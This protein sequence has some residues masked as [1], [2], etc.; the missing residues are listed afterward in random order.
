M[1]AIIGGATFC[2]VNYSPDHHRRHHKSV[3]GTIAVSAAKE[4]KETTRRST[5][6]AL[7]NTVIQRLS[8]KDYLER[9]KELI[10][11]DGG[12]PRWFSPLES[13]EQWSNS[14][15]LL[16]LPGMDGVGLGLIL[17]HQ[18]LGKMF[19]IW[20]LHIPVMDRTPFEELV[21]LVERTVQSENT[22]SPN[23][24]IYLVGESLGGCLALS[25][26]AR[27]P[28]VDLMLILA[29]PGDPFKMVMAAV[30]KELPLQQ[31][32]EGLSENLST[33]LPS[34]SVLA[35]ILPRESLLWKLEMLKSGASYANSRIHA[36][37]SETLILA[38]GRD[39][40]LPSRDEAERLYQMLPSCQIRNF[41]DNG[42]TLLME[43]GIDL[44]TIIKGAGFY[45]RKN[46]LDYIS[47]FMPPTP[48]EFQQVY[49]PS[50]RWVD[51]ATSPVFFSTLENGEIVRG[52]A[53]IPQEG[54]VVFVGYHMLL[55]LELGPLFAQF[56][57]ERDILLRGLAHPFMF[58]KSWERSLQ[59]SSSF[60]LYRLLG[61]VPVSASGFYK[62]LSTK[63]HV[64]LYPG[65]VREALHR[66]GE[67][68]KLF[69][70]LQSEFVRM[71]ARFG[72]KI[73]PFGVIGE[74]ELFD[75]F[76]DYDDYMKF[77][78]A[79]AQIEE[80]NNGRVRRLRSDINGAV[81]EEDLHFP[82]ILPKV[83]G[84]FY[85]M[86]GKPIDT[87][88]QKEELRDR[89]K[90]HELY[91]QIKSQVEGN[92]SYLKEKRENDPYRSFLSRLVYQATHGPN[93]Q[94]P[95]FDL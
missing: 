53:G 91:L 40:L 19:D 49:E 1:A 15:L 71:A 48:L 25:V 57:H 86:F 84:R 18:R 7:D 63:S 75:I 37:K 89:E 43:D 4:I 74:D 67:E 38:S 82:G 83:P 36:I 32:V 56:L 10:R 52:L 60:D 87:Q 31:T 46:T 55:G 72:A 92:I 6:K 61:G 35:D 3:T 39:Q 95:T 93:S 28:D 94:I 79:K 59:D 20:C 76:I 26:A 42:H 9:S 11:S 50:Y 23:R 85:F 58:G 17:H 5:L 78:Y 21:H 41:N 70:P 47:D 64:L 8:V 88:D 77:P 62:L 45:R 34:L 69:W 81:A 54:P 16:Y 2:T 14:P 30:E 80:L 27:N 65:G 73:V 24:P 90:A 51:I 33:L 13:R 44:V 68:Y 12:P 29:N 22:R 66:K